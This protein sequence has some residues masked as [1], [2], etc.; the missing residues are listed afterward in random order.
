[1]LSIFVALDLLSKAVTAIVCETCD[2]DEV[3]L[4]QT[5]IRQVARV[6]G[7]P[8]AHIK[9]LHGFPL[10]EP[11]QEGDLSLELAQVTYSDH[12][13]FSQMVH[14]H[15][16]AV[17]AEIQAPHGFLRHVTS[18]RTYFQMHI[19]KT[20][21]ASLTQNLLHDG[22]R[23]GDGL[24]VHERC[25]SELVSCMAK[26]DKLLT[27][28]REPRH[29]TQ[30]LYF[31]CVD[32]PWGQKVARKSGHAGAAVM[33]TFTTWLSYFSSNF[34]KESFGCYH[35][36]NL[37]SRSFVCHEKQHFAFSSAPPL[38]AA[39]LEQM[40]KYLAIG[41]AERY[42]ESVCLMEAMIRGEVPSYCNCSDPAA[43]ASFPIF[44]EAHGVRA[45]S[46]DDISQDELSMIDSLTEIDA[47]VYKAGVERFLQDMTGVEQKF[48]V[49]ILCDRKI[50]SE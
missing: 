30:S 44:E 46:V 43:W 17:A 45:H 19:P 39:V 28:V 32:S 29:H 5:S 16:V 2:N 18:G 31:E 33:A 24:Y 50:L 15:H 35:P 40:D 4:L 14:R 37:Q 22:L 8:H 21:G 25:Q 7:S 42:Q 3:F 1:M 6:S 41:V 23:A 26:Q 34:T 27:M 38:V 9:V 36:F 49:K 10:E 48:G 12:S 13:K 47:M 11:P 20:A